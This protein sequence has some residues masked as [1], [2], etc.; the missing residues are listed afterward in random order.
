ML[1]IFY[2][3]S[4]VNDTDGNTLEPIEIELTTFLKRKTPPYRISNYNCLCFETPKLTFVSNNNIIWW[5]F[6]FQL[7]L[8]RDD[9]GMGN[10]RESQ[11]NGNTFNPI[12]CCV[13]GRT[14]A[15]NWYN[16]LTSTDIQNM[17][18]FN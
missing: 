12:G 7:K 5:L 9:L 13:I 18:K 2:V 1:H 8:E 3:E 6:L 4:K 17:G 10:N 15:H 11:V 14:T 16:P